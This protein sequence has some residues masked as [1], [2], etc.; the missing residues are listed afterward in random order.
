MKK[1]FLGFLFFFTVFALSG[2]DLSNS[3]PNEET[4]AYETWRVSEDALDLNGDQ[5]INEDDYQLY[6]EETDYETWRNSEDALDLN[7]DRK[8]N[9]DDYDLYL[10]EENY[11]TWR[12]SEDALDLNG[13]RKIDEEDYLLSQIEDSYES[14]RNSDEALDL[15]DDQRIDDYDYFLYQTQD[16][17]EE[18]RVSEDA[19]DLNDDRRIDENDYLIYQ[20]YLVFSGT[21][22]IT[23]YLYDGLESNYVYGEN[24]LRVPEFGDLLMQMTINVG[25]NG[26]IT[27]DIPASVILELGDLYTTFVEAG[28]NMSITKIS[29][30]IVSIDTF[31]TVD[32]LIYNVSMYLEENENGY[33]ASYII[34]FYPDNPLI[35]FDLVKGE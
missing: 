25:N 20:D 6:L 35:T 2:C 21:Y 23:N 34:G 11:D 14:W 30:F 17:F 24:K 1:L 7:G 28:E 9:K 8:I 18:W 27:L 31:L 13:D 32:G 12:N 22:T 15:N 10:S 3:D 19:L 26:Q 16:D 5:K 33:T 29:P 4:I